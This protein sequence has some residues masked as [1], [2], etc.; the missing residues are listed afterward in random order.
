MQTNDAL[1]PLVVSQ[2]TACLMMS[3][4]PTRLYELLNTGELESFRDGAS[5]KI[6]LASIKARVD[7]CLARAKAEEARK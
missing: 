7:R 4:G 5:R 3:V 6:T 1:E 2:K